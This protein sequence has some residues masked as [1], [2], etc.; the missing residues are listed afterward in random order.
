MLAG[1]Y[2]DVGSGKTLLLMDYAVKPIYKKFY[3]NFK[4]FKMSKYEPLKLED[5]FN[6]VPNAPVTLFGFDEG[7]TLIESRTSLEKLNRYISYALFQCR[8]A[9]RD[10]ISTAQL[11][12]TLDLR[13]K[14]MERFTVY[15]F[16]HDEKSQDDF[17]YAYITEF[18]V[19]F[20]SLN[21]KYAKKHLFGLYDTEEIIL[22]HDFKEL[23]EE[24]ILSDP[25]KLKIKVNQVLSRLKKEDRFP[26]K[27][28][29]DT[30]LAMLLDM[31]ESSV[32]EPFLYPILKSV[33]LQKAKE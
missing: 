6:Y 27:V 20:W 14:D 24:I 21:F 29:H 31:E 11:K 33:E 25:K 32:I 19:T 5:L 22:P 13:F 3:A 17:K 26:Y 28:T 18:S 2:G 8:K 12:S 15:A 30:V 23:Q 1:F 9:H 7:Y 4:V 10:F 16:P